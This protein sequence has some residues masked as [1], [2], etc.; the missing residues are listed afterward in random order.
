[1]RSCDD[2]G[3]G[4][5]HVPAPPPGTDPRHAAAQVCAQGDRDHGQEEE[6]VPLVHGREWCVLVAVRI[7]IYIYIYIYGRESIVRS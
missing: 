2:N 4:P 5:L 7:Y 6:D 1:M 3:G